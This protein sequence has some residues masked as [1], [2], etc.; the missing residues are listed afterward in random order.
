MNDKGVHVTDQDK[1]QTGQTN[2]PEA[3]YAEASERDVLQMWQE[4]PI[5]KQVS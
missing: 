4:G 2:R 3:F 5:C 1:G